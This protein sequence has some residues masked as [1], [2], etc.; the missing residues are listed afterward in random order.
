MFIKKLSLSNFRNYHRLEIDFSNHINV[1]IGKNAQGK[2][3]LIE[4]IFAL[5]TTKSHRTSKDLQMVRMGEEFGKIDGIVESDEIFDLTLVLSKKGKRAKYNGIDFRLLS[6]YIGKLKVVFFAPEDLLMIKGSPTVRRRFLN[7]AIGQTDGLYLHHL[8]QYN[9]ILKQRNE[10]LKTF[11][12]KVENQLM[13]EV[14]TQQLIPHLIYIHEK[15]IWFLSALER[16]GSRVHQHVTESGELLGLKYVSSLKVD[17][18]IE[19]EVFRRYEANYG[20]DKRM[21]T[22]GIGLHRDDFLVEVD[23]MNASCYASQ[24]QQRTAVLSMKFAEIDLVH[25][26]SG[27]YPLLLLDDVLS[28]L[29]SSRQSKLLSVTNDQVQT[30]ITTTSIDGI[31]DEIVKMADVFEVKQAEIRKVDF[32]SESMS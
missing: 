1:V 4:A 21:R 32:D 10:L 16:H 22:T 5:S 9:Q 11:V 24:G 12:E 29:D 13:L 23:G 6:E 3:S 27:I 18:M 14:L 30:F 28:E 25:E 26:V 19:E 7:M 15:R 17:E 2:T 20:V 8:S 31:D